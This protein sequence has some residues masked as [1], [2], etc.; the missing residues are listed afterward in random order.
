MVVLFVLAIAL[1][2][3]GGTTPTTNAATTGPTGTLTVGINADPPNLDP[4]QSTALVDR[5]VQY[6]IFDRLY[7][8]N[9][10]LQIVPML[11]SAM[12][13]IKNGGLVY[14]IPLRHG[15][16]FTDGTPFNAAA[17][18]FNLNR[19]MN[20]NS[21]RSSE[22]S[23]VKSVAAAG[24]YTVKLTLKAPYAPLLSML[25]DRSGMMGSPKAIQKWGNAFDQHPVGTGPFIYVSRIPGDQIVLKANPHY[26][27]QGEPKVANLVYKVVTDPNVEAANLQAGQLDIIDT[28]TSQTQATLN[29]DPSVKVYA[30]PGIGYQG[31]FLNTTA[32]PFNNVYLRRAVSEAIDR[33]QLVNV[34]LKGTAVA[35]NGPFAPGTPAASASGSVPAVNDT[36]A[37]AD[38]AQGGHPGGFSFVFKT[39]AGS[40]VTLEIAQAIQSMLAKANI[41][42]S[43]QQEQFGTLLQ[44]CDGKNYQACALGWSGRADPDGNIY[45]FFYTGAGLNDAGYSN[46]QVDTWLNQARAE[47]DMT[48][49][50]Q[51]YTQIMNQLHQDVPYVFLYFP[52]NLIA[53]STKVKGFVNYPD[54]IIRVANVSVSK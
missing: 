12:P 4:A 53:A 28:V 29:G 44:D 47:T 49:R 52:K 18:V 7:A 24:P 45:S 37:K 42:M 34:V 33:T 38:L 19:Y 10:H 25:T 21:P 8:L 11:A 5:Y 17:V 30:T 50:V 48:Q 26:W 40:P 27:M 9:D 39:A 2:G 20:P 46:Q 51:L 36:Q 32:P 43:I 15:I 23:S 31:F 6:S 35:G 16:K 54:G 13:T 22:L 3:C 1:V 41:T 14:I